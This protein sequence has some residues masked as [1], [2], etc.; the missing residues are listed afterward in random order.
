MPR[1]FP[2]VPPLFPLW[3]AHE[4]PARRNLPPQVD[5][6][7]PRFDPSEQI[8]GRRR[9]VIKEP[10][11]Q[12]LGCAL[13]IGPFLGDDPGRGIEE[14]EVVARTALH[15][16]HVVELCRGEDPVAPHQQQVD[17]GLLE[18]LVR[19]RAKRPELPFEL[20]T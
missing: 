10:L 5:A 11:A 1:T 18:A 13:G 3:T 12:L 19:L 2:V 7:I 9:D 4:E 20:A 6:A 17:I 8:L 15:L 16:E 14:E